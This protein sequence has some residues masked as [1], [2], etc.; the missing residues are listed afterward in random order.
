MVNIIGQF[1]ELYSLYMMFLVIAI[2][3][4]TFF[5]DQPSLSKKKL[6]R[7][8]KLARI[9]GLSYIIGGP[10]IYIILMLI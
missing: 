6:K 4:F 5:L 8:A 2:G 9:I 10:L 3:L 7:D 1:K